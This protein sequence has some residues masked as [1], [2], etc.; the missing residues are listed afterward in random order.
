MNVLLCQ[1]NGGVVMEKWKAA[2]KDYVQGMKYKDIATKYDV[3]INTVKSWKKRHWS[4]DAP[5]SK[6]YAYKTKRG[7]SKVI[8]DL[9]ANK[10]L[11]DKQKLFCLYYIQRYNATW[12]YQQAYGGSYNTAKVEGS[13]T[14]AKP[15]VRNQLAKLQAS[16]SNDLYFDAVDAMGELAKLAFSSIG[17]VIEFK[18]VK[19]MKWVKIRDEK[20]QYEDNSGNYRLDPVVDVDTGK[21]AY[22]YENII[23]LRSSDEIDASSIKSIRIDKGNAIVEMYD[24]QKALGILLKYLNKFTSTAEQGN[25]VI[26]DDIDK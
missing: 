17:D 11:T 13:R 12:A 2:R 10:E 14:L 23:R 26:V 24:K 20:G 25:T 5:I 9:D 3:S 22:Y 21:Q 19:H 7:A 6:K 18:S 16:Q 15:N 8:N 1:H 4:N